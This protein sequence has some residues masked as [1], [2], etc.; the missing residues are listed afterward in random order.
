MACIRELVFEDACLGRYRNKSL[1]S[2]DRLC[3]V[4]NL[5]FFYAAKYTFPRRCDPLLISEIEK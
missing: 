3:Q 1:Q 4:C 2:K 5:V